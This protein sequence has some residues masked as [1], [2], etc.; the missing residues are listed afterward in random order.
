MTKIY[1]F[2]ANTPRIIYL[3]ATCASFNCFRSYSMGYVC[4]CA[5]EKES[6]WVWLNALHSI[7]HHTHCNPN[8]NQASKQ[9]KESKHFDVR[10]RHYY[11]YACFL[12]LLLTLSFHCSFDNFFSSFSFIYWYSLYF[13]FGHLSFERARPHFNTLPKYNIVL[14][15]CFWKRTNCLCLLLTRPFRKSTT[16]RYLFIII[17]GILLANIFEFSTLF[18]QL[19][20]ILFGG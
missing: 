3:C 7:V 18:F 17:M 1:C 19:N 2:K 5:R 6:V 9:E 13:I 16:I 20:S 14:D 11:Y 8:E 15:F 12:L 10:C 4:M